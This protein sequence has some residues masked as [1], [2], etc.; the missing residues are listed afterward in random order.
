MT[1]TTNVSMP[2]VQRPTNIVE[3]I[4]LITSAIKELRGEE[5][6]LDNNFTFKEV[7]TA[8]NNDKNFYTSLTNLIGTKLN[9]S[10]YT[11]ADVLAKLKTVD[12]INSGLDADLV[13]GY[14]PTNKA[15]DTMTGFLT[16]NADPINVMHAATKQY[17]DSMI[18]GFSIKKSVRA[19]A[20]SNI[21]LKGL[22]TVDDVKLNEGDRVLVINQATRSQNGIYNASAN[23]WTRT[24]DADQDAEFQNGAATFVLEGTNYAD[25]GWVLTTD[26][27][28]VVGTTPL[29]FDKFSGAGQIIPVDGLYK[30][31]N[32]MG[33]TDTGVAAGTYTKVT[34][35]IKG[36]VKAGTTLVPADIPDLSWVKITSGKPTTLGGYGIT[37]A[38]NVSEMVTA[39]TPNKLLKLDANSKLPASIT[40]NADGNAGT[41]TKLQTARKISLAGDV[42]GNATFDGTGDI[43]ITAAYKNS[44]VTAG[45]YTK[46]TVDAK[47]VV[48]SATTLSATDIP[49]LDW[50]KITSGKPTTL[51]G[52]A[53]TDAVNIS[54]VVTTATANKILK[55]DAM[56]KLPTSI[57]GNADGNAA[58]A[59]KLQTARKINLT[60]DVT[61]TVTFDGSG[62]ANI[63]T[64]YKKSGVTAGTYTKVTVDDKGNVTS[65]TNMVEADVPNIGWNKI[66]NKPTTIAGYGITD[67]VERF[68]LPS[69]S[70]TVSYVKIAELNTNIGSGENGFIFYV[71]GISDFAGNRMG[72][73][74]IQGSTRSTAKL[75]AFRLIRGSID[76]VSYGIVINSTTGL[77]EYWLKRDKFNYGINIIVGNTKGVI[78]YGN[79]LTSTTEPAG[80]NYVTKE[81][82]AT[83]SDNV[84]SASKLQFAKNITLYGDVSG[85]VEFDGTTNANIVTTYKKSG[86]VAGTYTKVT[87]DDKGVVTSATNQTAADI[88]NLDWTKITSGKPTTLA[89]YGI[90]DA[91]PL[92][93]DHPEFLKLD[94]SRQMTG[95]LTLSADPIQP[96][97]A[98]TKQYVDGL[99]QGI[100]ART[101]AYVATTGNI[102]LSASQ[103]IDGVTVTTG[104]RVLVKNQTNATQNGIYIAKDSAWV[105]AQ[106]YDENEEFT[107][108]IFVFVQ[109]G[110]VQGDTGWILDNDNA[111]TIGTTPLNFVQFSRAGVTEGDGTTIVRN[112]NI[113]SQ[114]SG[115]IP[116]T[117]TYTKVTVDTY[118]RVTAGASL[119]ASDIPNL[120]WTKITSGKPTTLSG[121]GITDAAP[122][123]HMTTIATKTVL[124][125][126]KE[127]NGVVIGADG[128]VAADVDGTSIVLSG[129]APNQKIS[130]AKTSTQASVTN[131]NNTVIQSIGVD[132]N[133]HVTTISSK[134]LTY[135]DVSAVPTSDVVTTAS[136]NKILKLD[137]NSKLPASITGNADGNAATASKLQ[138]ARTISLTGDVTG[139]VSF[140][141]SGNASMTTTFKNSGV[142]A[143]T[144][145]KVTTDAKGNIIGGSNPSTAAD[146]GITDVK[147]IDGKGVYIASNSEVDGLG[148]WT[149]VATITINARY[150]W[151]NTTI[152][153]VAGSDGSPNYRKAV[154][155]LRVKQQEAMGSL[156]GC[157][158]SLVE[159]RGMGYGDFMGVLSINDGSKTVVDLYIRVPTTHEIFFFTPLIQT[160]DNSI[161]NITFL[162]KQPFVASLPSN[163]KINCNDISVNTHM[164]TPAS[165]TVLGH[166]KSGDGIK[167]A[168]DGTISVD[169][170]DGVKL[171]GTSPNKTL[172]SDVDGTTIVLTGTSPNKQISHAATST[173]SSSTNT[174]ATVIQSVS[175]DKNG[176]V[177]SLATKALA[178]GDIGAVPTSDV[179]TVATANKIL[180]LDGNG[181]LPASV[182]GNASTVGGIAAVNIV[183]KDAIN[184]AETRFNIGTWA[185]PHQGRTYAIKASG[186]ISTDIINIGGSINLQYNS[187]ENALDIV[188]I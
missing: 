176:H 15:G 33:L 186:G 23:A 101:T 128:A 132:G 138:T 170:G 171:V 11:A 4:G 34:V 60:G 10:A 184:T 67:G 142:T 127:G 168:A 2:P 178:V 71:N 76:V 143:G 118:G 77:T 137:G 129:T 163:T 16:L 29:E 146:A 187:T 112:G 114:K 156:P 97:H 175:I 83:L 82:M 121:Y 153:F 169:V 86:V 139:S 47:G 13:R 36:R 54:E 55:L 56:G 108:A 59:T 79:L 8:I 32:K 57:T 84:A 150:G 99:I 148:K 119:S 40:G 136:A 20:D 166:V 18:Q 126:V 12:G 44:G 31:G 17:V 51:D 149:K 162:E 180:K 89:G 179:V 103:T 182:T 100:K 19:L 38:I 116:A 50:S 63:T 46:V 161:C 134:A 151:I 81:T 80:I 124:G 88:P 117:G 75:E 106:E 65:A 45:T 96:M 154:L 3:W 1:I 140:D 113:I 173:A 159:A 58:T 133:G 26:S 141:G 181:N 37:D 145:T 104:M 165:N 122:S 6:F 64:T 62:D 25:S 91:A 5:W 22:L 24:I 123:S 111:V 131:T 93:H 27:P 61:G 109:K 66:L 42:T 167:A 152:L 92:V 52:Y 135:A 70:A 160:G 115:I 74:I 105:R 87:V 90:T 183:R 110:T 94:G 144:Y 120:D 188:F 72:M 98:T 102:T 53:I 43:T 185:D 164:A 28:I 48:T 174:G 130:H 21:E 30:T 85:T 41:A 95:Q 68:T 177:T 14:V 107:G 158:L 172:A 39:A 155:D 35:D 147:T 49:N 9:T 125:H 78:A 73:D 69:L 157:E 7:L